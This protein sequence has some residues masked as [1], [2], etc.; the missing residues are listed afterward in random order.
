MKNLV[1]GAGLIG[2]HLTALLTERGE[3]VHV[4]SRGAGHDLTQA[5]KYMDEFV[6]ADRVWFVAW[7]TGVRKNETPAAHEAAVLHANSELCR[8]VFGVLQATGKPFL[9]VSS[10]A[11]LSPDIFVLGV[12]KRLGEMWTRLLGGHIARFWNV[13]GW[14]P[15]GEKSHLVPDL[16]WKGMTEGIVSLMS[17]GEETRQFLHARDAAEALVHQFTIGQKVAD[18]TSGEWV[19]VKT[20]AERI[21][22][23]LN[24]QV[25]VGENAGKP[26]LAIPQTPLA[27]WK[28]RLTLDEGLREVIKNTQAAE[29]E[30]P[31]ISLLCAVRNDERFI[32]ATLNTVV[33]QTYP[34]M[35]LIV[36]DGASTDRTARIARQYA[37][38]YENPRIMVVS[39]P[40]TGQW[41]A[42]D[43]AF[44]LSKGTYIG[45]V[46]GQDG[47][48]NK[49]WLAECIAAFKKNPDVSL[50]WGI[51]F[52]MSEDGKLVGPHYAYAGFLEDFRYG[53]HTQPLRTF[54]AKVDWHRRGAVMRFFRLI[55]KL[56][57]PRLKMVMRSFRKERIPQKKDW[58]SYWLV[59][60]RAFPEGNMV[61]RRAA[62]ERNTTRFPHE[63]MTNAALLDFCYN[64]NAN[65][66]LAYGLP[67]AA[68]FGRHHA[69]GQT[70]R[71]H[72]AL[73][74]KRYYEKIGFLRKRIQAGGELI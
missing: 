22:A 41:D 5:E 34:N 38:R 3:E 53:T 13:Y 64:F 57:L 9:F 7:D 37:A 26:S 60:G 69:V 20:V 21:G 2:S 18:I 15:V 48:L 65:G 30:Y 16:V 61:V 51:P 8:S 28:P 10:Q 1:L 24:A 70:L 14:E 23:L 43:K 33:S 11:T 32:R 40:D 6:W 68:S 29:T 66:Y 4:L 56:T 12:M 55:G 46:C 19:A 42:L 52:N 31:L 25:I 50:V 71:D 54:A 27:S 36:M 45:L 72:D 59:T 58:L 17:N 74:T 47:Y 62:Y 67:L 44:A 35:E 63:T 73:L 49:D 39:E